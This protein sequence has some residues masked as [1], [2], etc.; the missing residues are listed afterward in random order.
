SA[1]FSYDATGKTGVHQITII[2]DPDN[3][4][5]EQSE[6]NN[7]AAKT[8]GV[9]NA[10]LWISEPYISPNGDGV[11][12]G[13]EFFFRLEAPQTV[14]VVVVNS[15]GESVR[16]FSGPEF[17]NT[18]G[19]TVTWDGLND[20]GMVVADGRYQIRLAMATNTVLGSLSVIVDNNRSPLTDALGTD[21]LYKTCSPRGFGGD[22]KWFPDESGMLFSMNNVPEYPQGLY[23]MSPDG[24][25]SSR[26]SP[27]EWSGQTDPDRNYRY[28]EYDLSSDGA[29]IAFVLNKY[30][31]GGW[32][33]STELWVM[34]GDGKNLTLLDSYLMWDTIDA[35]K[36]SP[37]GDYVVYSKNSVEMWIARS[38]GTGK[39][40]IDTFVNYYSVSIP[41]IRAIKWSPD[42]R[43]AAY[44]Y[45]YRNAFGGLD[46]QIRVYDMSGSAQTVLTVRGP[47]YRFAWV[48]DQKIIAFTPWET[49]E[50][51]LVDAAGA[52]NNVALP[53]KWTDGEYAVA[54]DRESFAFIDNGSRPARL[55]VS[56]IAGITSV[57]HEVNYPN[58]Y[59]DLRGIVW[60]PDGSK[61]AVV[62]ERSS[63][64]IFYSNDLMVID[65]KT[66]N[67]KRFPIGPYYSDLLKWLPDGKSILGSIDNGINVL[68]SETGA[69]VTIDPRTNSY[70]LTD[71]DRFVSSRGNHIAYT[72]SPG[73]AGA[74]PESGWVVVGSL[75]N[76]TADI[77]ALKAGTAVTLR[78]TAV[79][80]NFEGYTLEYADAKNPEAWSIIQPPS[81]I[82]IVNTVFTPFVPP[83]E[84]TFYVR[85]T[86]RDKAG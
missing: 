18:T 57:L 56:D 11:K 9:Q 1:S 13:T 58:G 10:N 40:L 74:C 55:Y 79:D 19:D 8:L 80:L 52:G 51:R 31:K 66:R 69:S 54:P 15:K 38:D 25:D 59:P 28:N 27:M 29:K 41:D 65:V 83:Y 39:T 75:M 84:G 5:T 32:R 64:P 14:Q 12:D 46:G 77:T 26:L 20:D 43:K 50:Y 2:I 3:A 62:E 33:E 68:N 7:T 85:L 23:I 71:T 78:G 21:Y 81:D 60:S 36:L 37:H 48:N 47:V 76:L 63:W 34:D 45:N 6:N 16:T 30:N 22:W 42:G 86:A 24:S 44:I 72:V 4:I 49:T 61:I 17:E 82:P 73:Q 35:I 53:G 70:K 67:K